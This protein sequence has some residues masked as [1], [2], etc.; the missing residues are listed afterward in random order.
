MAHSRR[1]P[2]SLPPDVGGIVRG[3]VVLA[4]GHFES[5]RRGGPRYFAPPT[6]FW[7]VSFRSKCS[8]AT[9]SCPSTTSIPRISCYI[10]PKYIPKSPVNS[11]GI[12]RDPS[13]PRLPAHRDVIAVARWWGER[14]DTPATR[15]RFGASTSDIMEFDVKCGPANFARYLSDM[16]QL[17]LE[18]LDADQAGPRLG[19]LAIDTTAV[20]VDRPLHRIC[21]ASLEQAATV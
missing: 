9:G 20:D 5:E 21:H 4:L 16:E 2:I 13:C 12:A 18:L 10:R 3:T 19:T 1:A 6:G 8:R 15:L 11:T 17:T 14:G 7:A